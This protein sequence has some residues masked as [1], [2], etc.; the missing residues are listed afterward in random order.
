VAPGEKTTR[1]RT[2]HQTLE[3]ID[4]WTRKKKEMSKT[5]V[6]CGK[7][8]LSGRT[9]GPVSELNLPYQLG[10]VADGGTAKRNTIHL[11]AIGKSKE[12]IT[13]H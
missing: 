6:K 10:K 5:K 7:K 1:R 2:I 8:P 9:K 4:G 12:K 13:D 3:M 11:G